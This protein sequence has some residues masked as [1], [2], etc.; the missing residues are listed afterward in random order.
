[1]L[2]AARSSDVYLT[3]LGILLTVVYM[4]GLVFRPRRQLARLGPDSILVLILYL[5]AIAAL[6]AVAPR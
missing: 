2:P 3:A 6:P 4:W 1:V 5:I